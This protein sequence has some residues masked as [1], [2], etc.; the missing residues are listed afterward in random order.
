MSGLT[1]SIPQAELCAQSTGGRRCPSRYEDPWAQ[2]M[3]GDSVRSA[4]APVFNSTRDVR[5][6]LR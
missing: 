3:E 5:M 6:R 1:A 4:A 2:V